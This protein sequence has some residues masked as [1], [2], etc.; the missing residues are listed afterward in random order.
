MRIELIYD[1]ECPNVGDTRVNL[2]RALVAAGWPLKW[3]EWNRSDANAPDEI[4]RLGSPAILVDGAEISEAE[5]FNSGRCCRMYRYAGERLR[6][7]PSADL[8]ASA[9]WR[10]KGHP[11]AAWIRKILPLPGV[12]IALLPK[13]ICPACWPAYA[14]LLSSV[15]LGFLVPSSN[16]FMLTVVSLALAL[17]AIALKAPTRRRSGVL[18][19]GTIAAVSIVFAKFVFNSG[20]VLH[21]G[22]FVLIGASAWNAWPIRPAAP[23]NCTQCSKS[24]NLN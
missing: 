3:T 13:L 24:M 5:N 15:G 6:G 12:G 1:D 16:L 19:L 18:V 10:R 7:V 14:A 20:V 9:L 11:V 23:P 2:M 4:R 17:G 8:I 21:A 22:V